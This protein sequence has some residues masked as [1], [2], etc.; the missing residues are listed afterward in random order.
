[1]HYTEIMKI[2]LETFFYLTDEQLRVLAN[3]AIAAGQIS[4]GSVV[5]PYIFPTLDETKIGMVLLG[6]SITL[7]FWSFSVWIIRRIR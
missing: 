5:I 3:V 1:M 7:F 4:A 2:N 6:G